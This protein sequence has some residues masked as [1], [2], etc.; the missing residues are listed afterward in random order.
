MYQSSHPAYNMYHLFNLIARKI[1]W[2]L[3]AIDGNFLLCFN[4]SNIANFSFNLYRFFLDILF[5]LRVLEMEIM[6]FIFGLK[7]CRIEFL[8]L[9]I[10][11]RPLICRDSR[12]RKHHCVHWH[13]MKRHGTMTPCA[14]CT[15]FDVC[16]RRFLHMKVDVL[17]YS[18]M[19]S[20]LKAVWFSSLEGVIYVAAKYYNLW[21]SIVGP[22][23]LSFR[24]FGERITYDIFVQHF[25]ILKSNLNMS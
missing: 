6:W 25:P 2:I 8:F 20:A 10:G 11:R 19:I 15:S 12:R 5:C 9:T 23:L 3:A 4:G 17:Q 18:V 7:V 21:T 14:P 22:I 1:C 16:G 13:Y 24:N